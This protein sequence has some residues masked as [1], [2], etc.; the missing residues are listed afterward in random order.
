MA[1]KVDKVEK[2]SFVVF[3]DSVPMRIP[4]D[5]E[6]DRFQLGA[7]PDLMYPECIWEITVINGRTFNITCTD[8]KK[9]GV[10]TC[11]V[12]EAFARVYFMAE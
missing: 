12:P 11:R 2:V 3:L 9:G 7:G 8:T 6:R 10:F 4:R 5:V 1:D